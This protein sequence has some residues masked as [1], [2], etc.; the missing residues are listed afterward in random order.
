VVKRSD[1]IQFTLEKYKLI[2]TIVLLLV[3]LLYSILPDY[4]WIV[5]PVE[6]LELRPIKIIGIA[7]LTGSLIFVKI[8]QNQLRDSYRIGVDHTQENVKLVTAGIYKYSRNPIALGMILSLIGFFL[9][10]PNAITLLVMVSGYIVAQIRIK[11]EEEHLQK[12]I[13]EEYNRYCKSTRKW[14]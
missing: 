7:V 10:I 1:P 13:G 12:N 2:I 4:Y 3:I 11:I 14:I 6:Y 5:F 8:S 9:L